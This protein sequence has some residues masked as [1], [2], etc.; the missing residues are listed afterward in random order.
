MSCLFFSS[1]YVFQ[2][3]IS[4][5]VRPQPLHCQSPVVVVHFPMHG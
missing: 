2:S 5:T 1:L 3:L 4:S